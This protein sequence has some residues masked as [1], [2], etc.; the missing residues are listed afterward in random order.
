MS[1][2]LPQ[3]WVE[4]TLGEGLAI[5]VQPGRIRLRPPP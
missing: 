4:A 2:E 5:D 3:G 1:D